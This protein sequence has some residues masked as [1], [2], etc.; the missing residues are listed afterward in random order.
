MTMAS[1]LAEKTRENFSSE[2]DK[3]GAI[4]GDNV[5]VG[6]N[7]SIMPGIKIG[8][9]SFVGAGIII[10]ENIHE[11][12]FVRGEVKLKISPNKFY[13]GALDRSKMRKKL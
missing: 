2:M 4:I 13:V 10:A 8:S 3:L 12:S 9:G 7:T 1:G 11:K 6:I 5:R